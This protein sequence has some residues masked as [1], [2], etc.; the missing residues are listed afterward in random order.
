MLGTCLCDSSRAWMTWAVELAKSRWIDGSANNDLHRRLNQA[1]KISTELNSLPVFGMNR[2]TRFALCIA[3]LTITVWCE[4]W[5]SKTRMAPVSLGT[6]LWMDWI[7]W[8]TDSLVVASDKMY[9]HFFHRDETPPCTVI[10]APLVLMPR[11]FL[12]WILNR[13][14]R[15]CQQCRML[16]KLKVEKGEWMGRR[17]RKPG[18]SGSKKRSE[19][20]DRS[21]QLPM[22]RASA[23]F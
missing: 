10:L 8:Q 9:L 5:W 18:R 11:S 23:G 3:F 12:R 13:L 4:V 22:L 7:H 20:G 14:C 15:S 1:Q 16:S 6:E 19:G 2:G 17:K 21:E